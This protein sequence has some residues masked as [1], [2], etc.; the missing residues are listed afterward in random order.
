MS[1]MMIQRRHSWCHFRFYSRDLSWLLYLLSELVIL[2][3]FLSRLQRETPLFQIDFKGRKFGVFR[4]VS[5]LGI[6][7]NSESF[8]HMKILG[9]KFANFYKEMYARGDKRC[10][11]EEV[12]E[13]LML[14]DIVEKVHLG[15]TEFQKWLSCNIKRQ[16]YFKQSKFFFFF[17]GYH[18]LI[19]LSWRTSLK[20]CASIDTLTC[21]RSCCSWRTVNFL[22][23]F[24][25]SCSKRYLHFLVLRITLRNNQLRTS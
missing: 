24:L 8:A 1:M 11:F 13:L 3:S 2:I 17:L 6:M 5:P 14:L 16:S 15:E 4:P 12:E 23:R 19:L 22:F 21:S 20:I 25:T 18:W 7:P 10:L 9:P